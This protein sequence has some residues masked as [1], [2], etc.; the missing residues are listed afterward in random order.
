MQHIIYNPDW[1]EQANV[2]KI[3][4]QIVQTHILI[5]EY[6]VCYVK[7]LLSINVCIQIII[8][9]LNLKYRIITWN[10][11]NRDNFFFFF[12]FHMGWMLL[13]WNRNLGFT[14]TIVFTSIPIIC[15]WGFYIEVQRAHFLRIFLWFLQLK[16][17]IFLKKKEF[18]IYII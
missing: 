4:K 5:I 13:K 17:Y 6:I 14:C 9:R 8:I 12:W 2:F 10:R 18:K 11:K 3:V 7:P 16:S 15:L 1:E